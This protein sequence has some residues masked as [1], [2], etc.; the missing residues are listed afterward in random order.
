[1]A[2]H[3]STVRCVLLFLLLS[4]ATSTRVLSQSIMDAK[5]VEFTPSADHSIVDASGNALVTSY[6]MTIFKAGATTP[7]QT[8]NLGKPSVGTDGFIRLDFS[9]L[10]T[11]PLATGISYEALIEAV[12]PGGR[13][14]GTRTNTF[15]YTPT[16]TA[17]AISAT[18]Q[19]FAAA[20][21]TGS[22]TVTTSG[23]CAWTAS[24]PQ[25]WVTI[26]SGAMGSGSGSVAFKVTANSSTTSRSATLTI[27]GKAFT[28]SEAGTGCS[29]T[30]APMSLTTT[31]T[32]FTGTLTIT[33]PAGCAWSASSPVSWITVSGSGSGNGTAS[34][35][36]LAN[37][38][39]AARSTTLTVAG[40][41]VS[42][43]QATA[44]KPMIVTNLR[45]VR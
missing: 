37:T 27:A 31:A 38:T 29:S 11:S 13:S 34:F 43:S 24:S 45:I 23:G 19:S 8:L 16:C 32:K 42:V 15:G 28:V 33:A 14:G 2:M 12:G 17:P 7:V 39:G 22:V 1:M 21:G 36:L 40:K 18:S 41:T 4:V 20:G 25:S 9:L 35:T 6:S 30:V 3:T 10:L 44:T 5:R 26:T